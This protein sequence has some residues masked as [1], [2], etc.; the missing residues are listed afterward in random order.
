M[1]KKKYEE[2]AE[3]LR[4]YV[5]TNIEIIKL[6]AA[7]RYSTAGSELLSGLIIG[8]IMF[9]LVFFLSFGLGYYLS[10]CLDSHFLGFVSVGGIYF[11]IGL[12][13]IFGRKKILRNPLRN[14]IIRNL[15]RHN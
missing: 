5:N 8:F 7:D 9:L 11:I 12:I 3:S 13:L 4:A 15:F 2:L 10:S 1:S 14:N 6:E